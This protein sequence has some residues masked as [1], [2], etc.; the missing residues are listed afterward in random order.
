MQSTHGF[1]GGSEVYGDFIQLLEAERTG[2]SYRDVLSRYMQFMVPT[3]T[4]K[5]LGHRYLTYDRYSF[6]KLF[7]E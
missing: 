6:P 5:K 3:S 2:I 7:M 1:V 4:T